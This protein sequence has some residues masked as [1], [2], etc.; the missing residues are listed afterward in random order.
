M[1]NMNTIFEAGKEKFNMTD[2]EMEAMKVLVI[3][4]FL[5]ETEENKKNDSSNP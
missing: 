1:E 4:Q 5:K 3:K 2:D